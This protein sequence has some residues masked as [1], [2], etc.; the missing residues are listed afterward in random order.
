MPPPMVLLWIL[1][2]LSVSGCAR[3]DSADAVYHLTYASLYSPMHPF[4]R[5]DQRWI[6]HIERETQGRLSI[7]PYWGGSVLS[8]EQNV[9]ELKHSVVDV[10][11]ITPIYT[12]GG[13]PTIR[14]QGSFY[15][16]VRS[17]ADQVT[18]F[19]CL[20][21]IEPVFEQEL[22][23][24]RVLAVQGGNFPGV[25]TRS[26]PIRTVADFAGMRLRAPNEYFATLRRLRADPVN[27]PMNEVYSALAKGVIDG[28]V[29]PADTL[30]SMHFAEV[31]SYFTN[32][33]FSR[34]AYPARAISESSWD[35]LPPDLQAALERSRPMWQAALSEEIGN[36]QQAGFRFAAEHEVEVIDFTPEQQALLDREFAAG[37]QEVAA[38]L[39]KL[40][41]PGPAILAQA[42]ALI[43]ELNAGKNRCSDEAQ[44]SHG[45]GMP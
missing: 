24:V 32:A 11:M 3:R 45:S 16:G 25:L 19:S 31:G 2:A 36:A 41:I 23:G 37:A 29:A 21:R 34:G 44:P 9:L 4:S 27:L 22:A 33:R 17:I 10:G 15:S 39:L 8:S 35:K 18:S 1:T 7:R 5:A 43:T 40:G 26:R 13:V 6:E 14:A 30:R 42:Q 28:V 20:M 12:R 38:D